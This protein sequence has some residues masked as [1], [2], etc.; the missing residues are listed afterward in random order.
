VKTKTEIIGAVVLAVAVPEDLIGSEI[1]SMNVVAENVIELEITIATVTVTATVTVDAA[2][3]VVVTVTEDIEVL[4]TIVRTVVVVMIMIEGMTT[5]E[6]GDMMMIDMSVVEAEAQ[7][8]KISNLNNSFRL[9][10]LYRIKKF[11]S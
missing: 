4:V 7:E 1:M 8:V 9:N 5:I 11:V 2:K 6:E 10:V 3:V